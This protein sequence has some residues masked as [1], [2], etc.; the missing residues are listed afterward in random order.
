MKK[1]DKKTSADWLKIIHKRQLKNDFEISDI[2]KE[3]IS[4]LKKCR[5]VF[6]PCIITAE[7]VDLIS[8]RY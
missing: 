6:R 8:K 7:G 2:L 3:V 4:I 1:S 5:A